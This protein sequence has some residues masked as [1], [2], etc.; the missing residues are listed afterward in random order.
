[1]AM[2][3]LQANRDKQ[4][5]ELNSIK[6]V[7]FGSGFQT[8]NNPANQP[9]DPSL[10]SVSGLANSAGG[11]GGWMGMLSKLFKKTPTDA[12]GAGSTLGAS[13]LGVGAMG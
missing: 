5:A 10:S 8:A 3:M 4:N 7:N 2:Q 9:G 1:M 6:P 12:A 11:E 13:D